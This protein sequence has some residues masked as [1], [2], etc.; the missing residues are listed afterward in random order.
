[1]YD[2]SHSKLFY[3]VQTI[4]QQTISTFSIFSPNLY[5]LCRVLWPNTFHTFKVL[6]FFTSENAFLVCC[7][8]NREATLS[9]NKIHYPQCCHRR[10]DK[11]NNKKKKILNDKIMNEI[12]QLCNCHRLLSVYSFFL[13]GNFFFIR[14]FFFHHLEE[15]EEIA[16][17]E[18]NQDRF[19]TFGEWQLLCFFFLCEKCWVNVFVDTRRE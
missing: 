6:Y 18:L 7:H 17:F 3:R 13:S 2:W 9:V 14:N 5:K 11:N 12:C 10:E 16:E 19:R 8:D 15:E 4:R 1:M